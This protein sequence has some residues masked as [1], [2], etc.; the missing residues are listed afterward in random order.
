VSKGEHA[1]HEIG[2]P[3]CG[4]GWHPS[5]VSCSCTDEID[6]DCPQH[7]YSASNNYGEP[8]S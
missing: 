6:I 1:Q 2:A 4:C 5:C 8:I 3:H 7:G